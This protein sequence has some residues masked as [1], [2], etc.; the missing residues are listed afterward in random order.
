MLFILSSYRVQ[1]ELK[2]DMEK[3]LHL[4]GR[5][6]LALPIFACHKM[7][8]EKFEFLLQQKMISKEILQHVC[9]NMTHTIAE[10]VKGEKLK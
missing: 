8:F 10:K 1:K 9:I 2:C 7:D 3:W 6:S 4:L 5:N